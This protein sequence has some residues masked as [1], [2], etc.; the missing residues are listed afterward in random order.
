MFL[1]YF[2]SQHDVVTGDY[3]RNV[4]T[5]RIGR[6]EIIGLKTSYAR[7]LRLEQTRSEDEIRKIEISRRKCLF[8]DEPYGKFYKNYTKNLCKISCRIQN[9]LDQCGCVPFFYPM[10]KEK[11]CRLTGMICLSKSNWTNV[12]SCK[13]IDMCEVDVFTSLENRIARDNYD[14]KVELKVI[15]PKTIYKRSVHF[16]FADLIGEKI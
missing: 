14:P 1:Q 3:T 13:C 2:H 11:S 4:N 8:V 7:T 15:L 6:G 9:A 5:L 10:I 16:D 12:T